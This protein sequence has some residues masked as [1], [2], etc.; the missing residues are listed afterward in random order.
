[1][2]VDLLSTLMAERKVHATFKIENKVCA[3]DIE[4][5]YNG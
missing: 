4:T 1:M 3:P 5:V 2:R